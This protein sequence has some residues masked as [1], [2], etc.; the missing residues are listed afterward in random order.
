MQLAPTPSRRLSSSGGSL[1][2]QLTMRLLNR[3]GRRGS[4]LS[5]GFTLIELMVVVAIIGILSAI[6][7]PKFI[8][9][10]T[11]AKIGARVGEALGVAKE[12]SVLTVTGVGTWTPGTTG[13]ATDGVVK[14]TC[15]ESTGG[16]VTATWGVTSGTGLGAAGVACANANPR[17]TKNDIKAVI[18]IASDGGI[19]C[20]F[21]TS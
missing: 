1:R 7:V 13:S 6:G 11:A 2:P 10:R 14:G 15:T 18:T 16:T 3:R 12:C 5:A 8:E 21:A 4:L 19:S 20:A 17:S 9:A